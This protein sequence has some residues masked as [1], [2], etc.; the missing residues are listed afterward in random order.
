MIYSCGRLAA[1]KAGL[2]GVAAE[3]KTARASRAR[4]VPGIN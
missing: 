4:T 2:A 1:D 3:K